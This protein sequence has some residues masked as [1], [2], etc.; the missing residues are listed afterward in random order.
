MVTDK[1][2]HVW[3]YSFKNEEIEGV[4]AGASEFIDNQKGTYSTSS[5]S[6]NL[7]YVG[8]DDRFNPTKGTRWSFSNQLAGLGGNISFLKTDIKHSMYYSPIEDY[9]VSLRLKGGYIFG[10]NDDKV[11]LKDRYF[12][13]ADSF[14]GFEVSGI[15]PR[16]TT[17]KNKDAL[18]GNLMYT[19]QT[20]LKFPIPG[21]APQ[22]GVNGVLFGI[23]GAVTEID[24]NGGEKIKDDSSPRISAGFGIQWKSPFGP[25]RFDF[26][27]AVMKEDYDRT[28]FFK[29]SF[30][31][32]F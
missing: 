19:A 17:S 32:T 28:Q 27:H 6:H 22:L 2:R 30:G 3:N 26:A 14:P 1:S 31:A 9:V 21:V 15:G 12:L 25:V 7:S 29:F 24:E 20:E 18:G 5:V 8:V 13:G 23:A 10:Y 16:D 11:K 4:K